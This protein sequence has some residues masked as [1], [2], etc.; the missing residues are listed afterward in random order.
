MVRFFVPGD[1]VA[2]GRPRAVRTRTGVRMHTPEKTERYERLVQHHA[3]L[4]SVGA[5]NGP[6]R[7]FLDFGIATPASWSKKRT[8]AALSGLE[9][10]CKRPDVDNLAK[11]VLDALNGIIYDDDV[12]VVELTVRKFYAVEPGVLVQ[13][14]HINMPPA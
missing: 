1:P 13:V 7:V 3:M 5:F 10:P 6:V 8:E 9:R 11:S 2:K 14:E 12:Q 4:A